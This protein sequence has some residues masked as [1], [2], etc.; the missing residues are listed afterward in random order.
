MKKIAL[1]YAPKGGSVNCMASMIAE[2]FGS[3]KVDMM[4]VSEVSADKI[5]E[6]DKIIFGNSSIHRGSNLA[7]GDKNWQDFLTQLKKIDLTGKKIAIFGLGNQLTYPDHFVDSIG[8]LADFLE[9]RNAKIFGKVMDEGYNYKKSRALRGDKFMGLPLDE[10]TEGDKS[11][12]RIDSWL[13]Q[14][15]KEF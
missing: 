8:D 1:F 13:I 11:E 5:I 4:C 9:E 10:E 14:L 6:Y 3:Q 15:K 7:D 2:K 12:A